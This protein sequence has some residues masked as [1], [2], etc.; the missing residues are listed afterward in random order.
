MTDATAVTNGTQNANRP[1]WV[2]LLA[3]AGVK[4]ALHIATNVN[5]GIFI[6]EFYYLAC[7]DHLDF[8]YVDHPPLIALT[9]WLARA[10]FGVSAPGL[11][12]IP[13]ILGS[14]TVLLAGLL[15]WK[16]GGGRFAQALAALAVTISPLLLFMN[17]ILSM[18]ALDAL[19][20]TLAACLLVLILNG[21]TRRFTTTHLWLLLGV[22]LGIGLQ[23]KI[24]VLFLG[25]G[26]ALGLVLTPHRRLLLTR[27]PWLAAALAAVIFLP[28]LL[29]QIGNGWPTLEFMHNATAFKNR[30]MSPVE[31][32][33]EQAFEAHPL[34]LILLLWG[35][36]WLFFAR[37]GR[38][39]RVFGWAYL[40]IFSLFLISNGKPYYLGPIY[41][42]MFSAG[43]CGIAALV[44][45][46]RP[47][48]AI[49][50]V[51]IVFG[52]LVAP[53]TLPV[54]PVERFVAYQRS[55]LGGA[56]PSSERKEVGSL[57]Q[58]FADMFGYEERVALIAEVFNELPPGDRSRCAIYCGEYGYAG[59]VDLYGPRYGLPRAI[60]GQNSYWLWGPGSTD[61]NL[62]IVIGEGIDGDDLRE[63]YNDV[64]VARLFR[65]PYVLPCRNNMPIFVCRGIKKPLEEVWLESKSYD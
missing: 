38:R 5:Y 3:I 34:N 16:L 8:G 32:I 39:Y 31:F 7:A 37:D 46:R 43:S 2:L 25:F 45:S 41:P 24:S 14:L 62:L 27:G 63:T 30:S 18:N 11:R 21:G 49:I 22:L 40:A 54:L 23:N 10:L 50:V 57:P 28:H 51:M 12:L 13:A 6:D 17:T 36:C 64:R 47:R 48:T 15:A 35:L 29:W 44:R 55:L 4:L 65:H 59:A 33:A 19:I 61:G 52:A 53:M 58:H 42:L 1:A 9:T 56:M 26:L 60:C 20:W